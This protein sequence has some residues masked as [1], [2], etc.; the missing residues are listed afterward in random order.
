MSVEAMARVLE[1]CPLK[2]T[3]KLVLL[4]I[5]NHD[6]DGG[7]WPGIDT[8]ARYASVERRN[9]QRA[10]LDLVN[11]GWIVRHVNDGGNRRTRGDRRPNRYEIV[12]SRFNGAAESSPREDDGAARTV[13]RGGADGPHGAADAPPEPS[14]NLQENHPTRDKLFDA[15]W[16]AYPKKVSRGRAREAWARLVKRGADPYEMIEGARRY[17]R[18]RDGEDQQFTKYPASWL[19]AECWADEVPA[20]PADGRSELADGF[21]SPEEDWMRATPPPKWDA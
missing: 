12:W 2:G 19:N 17:A 6:G 7:S 10:V 20:P 9:A 5:A 1:R 21:V 11:D 3:Q 14:L 16:S 13:E 8:L 4:G 15:F 18:Q